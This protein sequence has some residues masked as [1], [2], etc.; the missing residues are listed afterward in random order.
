MA[1]RNEIVQRIATAIAL[2][3]GSK[4][5]V[6]NRDGNQTVASLHGYG[7]YGDA[8]ERYARDHWQEYSAAAEFVTKL[9]LRNGRGR[10]KMLELR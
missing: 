10:L 9:R 4:F 6:H 5:V 2:F 8:S 1:S 7:H 3:H